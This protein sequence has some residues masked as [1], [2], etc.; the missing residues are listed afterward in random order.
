VCFDFSDT[1]GVLA[2]HFYDAGFGGEVS[3][4]FI[5][6]SRRGLFAR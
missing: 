3:S 1:H 4:T 5:L 2:I 6:A